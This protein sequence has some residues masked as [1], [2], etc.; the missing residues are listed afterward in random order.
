MLRPLV[1]GG[2]MPTLAKLIRNGASGNLATIR[3]VV[4]PMLWTSI[5]TGKRADKHGVCGFVEPSRDRTGLRPVSSTSRSCKAI[6][7]ILSQVGMTSRVVGWCASHPAEPIRG[8]VVS[9]RFAACWRD[10]EEELSFAPQTFFPASVEHQ[11]GPR[12][13]RA[14]DVQPDMILPFVPQLGQVEWKSDTRIRNLARL[15]ARTSSVH[16]AACHQIA[17]RPWDF[18]AIHYPAIG[19]FGRCFGPFS[20]K[21]SDAGHQGDN[22]AGD[23]MIGCCRFL[24]MMLEAL[25]TLAGLD[26]T[27]LLVSDHG[28]AS[29]IQQSRTGTPEWDAFSQYGFG[30]AC[31]QGPGIRR[32]TLLHGAT[33][34]DVTP[35]ILT[36]LGLVIGNDM[37]GRTWHEI[38]EEPVMSKHID[39]WESVRGNTGRH[40]EDIPATPR[41][42]SDALHLLTELGYLNFTS[43]DVHDVI[44]TVSKNSRIHLAIALTDSDRVDQAIEHW[45]A[46]VAD[47]PEESSYAI[48]LASCYIRLDRWTECKSTLAQIEAEAREFPIVQLMLAKIALKEGEHAESISIARELAEQ[49]SGN[50]HMLN[51]IGDLLFQANAW[52]DAESV[53]QSSL[54]V[55]ENNPLA[56]D[57]LAKVYLEL[58]HLEAAVEHATKA[59]ELIHHFPAAYFHLGSALHYAGRDEEAIAAFET[60]LSMGYELEESHC[61]LAGLYLLRD[62]VKAKQHR[63]SANLH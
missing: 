10:E 18:M 53:F 52:K 5:A 2:A 11:I 26:T 31:V 58:D 13:V 33:V 50:S 22:L 55:N 6:W 17:Q 40:P 16:A 44:S 21:H 51:R 37:D 14:S 24:D 63:D 3:P 46:L 23:I 54:A 35:T 59:V 42:T 7:N 29:G 8:S 30:V 19:D 1:D 45:V 32:G 62:P 41:D 9:D 28:F 27:V 25:L 36:M 43:Y 34:L 15:I 12:C 57:G 38:L 60:C 47:Y 61:R 56:H 49:T 39:S 48:Q 4:S 20:G